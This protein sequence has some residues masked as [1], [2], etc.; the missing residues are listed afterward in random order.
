MSDQ[1]SRDYSLRDYL[2][3]LRR[4]AVVL[5]AVTIAFTGAAFGLSVTQDPT[6]ESQS[7]VQF[8]DIA[9]EAGLT[10]SLDLPSGVSPLVRAASK[11]EEV[12]SIETAERVRR[13]LGTDIPARSLRSAIS[14][15]VGA[16]TIFVQITA[17]WS[18]P[19]FAAELANAFAEVS[20]A[21]ENQ[22]LARALAS[23]IDN[24][25]AAAK[26]DLTDDAGNVN[27]DVFN[28]RNQLGE[29]T[30]L[31]NLV[32]DGVVASAEITRSAE[33]PRSPS[34]PQTARNTILGFI[35]G[36]SLGLLAAF[37][38]DSLDRR[39]RSTT[40]AHEQFGLPV[41]GRVGTT[42]MGWTGAAGASNGAG[43]VTPADLEA[44]RILRSNLASLNPESPPRTVLVTSGLPQE[45]KSTVAASL[46]AASAAAGQRTLLVDADLRRPV[47]AKRLGLEGTPGLA[48]YLSGSAEPN[49]ILKTVALPSSTFNGRGH[50]AREKG[51]SAK[52]Q[53]SEIEEG[54]TGRTLVCIP[55]GNLRGQP[56]ELLASEPAR[57][58]LDKVGRAY[59]L[60][61]LDSSPLLATADPLEL[62]AH[63]DAVLV[64][65]RLSSSTAEEA[66]AVKDAIALLPERPSGLVVTGAGSSDAY[67]GYY[68]Y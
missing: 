46:A 47:L 61:V 18:D 58:F 32:D 43:T 44:F 10:T 15:S 22:Q 67:Y 28:A 50:P 52:N 3:L 57:D 8:N 1:E 9:Q 2:A 39:I 25:R 26:G 23:S 14:A 62:M 60:V 53:P 55:A 4:Q 36:I 12:T 56:A 48:D 38:R 49:S 41:L 24:R 40:D 27:L 34:S 37:A 30:N 66:R 11:A 7:A 63:V 20:I 13:R 17:R 42:A 6:Y 65:V 54:E 33:V 45:G 29:L 31:K 16:Q 35:V 51:R 5:V 64:C 21:D 19:D 59:D 68:G